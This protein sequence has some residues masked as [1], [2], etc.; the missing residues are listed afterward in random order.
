MTLKLSNLAVSSGRKAKDESLFSGLWLRW[1]ALNPA[2]RFVCANILLMP[3]WWLAGLLDYMPELLLAGVVLYEWRRYGGLRLLKRPSLIVIA[4]FAFNA[5]YFIDA[6]LIFFDANPAIAAAD[7]PRDFITVNYLIK[8]LFDFSVPCLAWYIQSNNVR[9]RLEVVA[10]A[11]SAS[12]VQMLVTWLVIQFFPGA[13]DNPPRSLYGML[14]GKSKDYVDGLG[15]NNYLL[16]YDQTKR[17]RFFFG[18]NQPCAAFL[19]FA[20][21]LVLDIKNRFWSLLLIVGCAFLL[22]LSAT[23][24]VWLALP[25]ALIIGFLLKSSKVKGAW[26]VFAL[27]A[28][29]S[30][31]ILSVPPV[32][33]FVFNT[34]TGTA[35]AIGDVRGGSTAGRLNVYKQTLQEI[36]NKPFFGH[37]VEGEKVT[38]T[39]GNDPFGPEVGSHS[40][41]LGILLYQGGLVGFGLFV[42][43]WASLIF[44]FYNTR[45]SRPATW[46]SQML[47]FSLQLNVTGLQLTMTI[48]ILILMMLRKPALNLNRS[49]S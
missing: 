48:S 13:F 42:T 47:F 23:R 43:F 25:A 44:W 29:V 36:P 26:L 38:T 3:A 6:F 40:F 9:V 34:A 49:A 24:S 8:L 12:I 46:F 18:N 35:T 10:W 1:S 28:I 5:Y 11:V 7:V 39:V 4:W 37:K 27:L 30:F 33:N 21:L 15:T 19:G 14:T 32:S 31:S 2:E 16:L 20:G 41:I 17:Y 45:D 22:S